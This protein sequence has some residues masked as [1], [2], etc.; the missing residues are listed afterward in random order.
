VARQHVVVIECHQKM[1]LVRLWPMA[2]ESEVSMPSYQVLL[3]YTIADYKDILPFRH[4]GGDLRNQFGLFGE[5]T[6]LQNSFAAAA[7][8]ELSHL[9]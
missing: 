6:Q 4:I 1:V 8:K 2:E 9:R 7:F 3:L 5:E